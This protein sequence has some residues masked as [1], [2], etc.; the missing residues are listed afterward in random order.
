[1]RRTTHSEDLS[2][3]DGFYCPTKPRSNSSDSHYQFAIRKTN[4]KTNSNRLHGEPNRKNRNSIQFANRFRRRTLCRQKRPET[5]F[6]QAS[7]RIGPNSPTPGSPQKMPQMTEF[8]NF[9]QW[10]KGGRPPR[11]GPKASFGMEMVGTGAENHEEPENS[12]CKNTSNNKK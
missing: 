9:R 7:P 5:N 4:R 1:M 3:A 2:E 12:T 6:G 10:E 8:C 11:I